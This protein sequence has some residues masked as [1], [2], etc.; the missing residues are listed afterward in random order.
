MNIDWFLINEGYQVTDGNSYFA[1]SP[2]RAQ[3]MMLYEN[4]GYHPLPVTSKRS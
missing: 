3:V 1:L 2:T 4:N